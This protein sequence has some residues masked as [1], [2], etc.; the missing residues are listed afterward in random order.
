[1]PLVGPDAPIERQRPPWRGLVVGAAAAAVF[2]VVLSVAAYATR[3]RAGPVRSAPLDA[4]SQADDT[5]DAGAIMA[6]AG[7][8]T[9]DA[10]EVP[11]AEPEPDGGPLG[12]AGPPVELA[13]LVTATQPLLQGCLQDALRFDPSWGGKLRVRVELRGRT[14]RA[15]PP[16]GASPVFTQ[17]LAQ[18]SARLEGAPATA[19]AEL[20]VALDGLRG[21]ASVLDANLVE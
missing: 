19:N 17:C 6:D 5:S 13:A 9:T 7:A 15:L 11:T 12:P 8:P 10:G 4:G 20:S 18:R 3:D 21:T 16:P 2:L 1:M 14:V